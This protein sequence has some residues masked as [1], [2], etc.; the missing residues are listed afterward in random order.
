MT[1]VKALQERFV[2]EGVSGVFVS[3]LL[4]DAPSGTLPT[5]EVEGVY[6]NP[7]IASHLKGFRI[8]TVTS[9]QA[10]TR[11][12][13]RA[14]DSELAPLSAE[15]MEIFQSPD[16]WFWHWPRRTSAGTTTFESIE[17]APGAL[18]AFLAQRLAGLAFTAED[19]MAGFTIVDVLDRIHGNFDSTNVTR[20]FYERFAA[21]HKSLAGEIAGLSEQFASDYSTTLLNRMMFLYFLQKKEFLNGDLWYLEHTLSAV[22][23]LKGRD[24]YYNFYRDALLPLFFERLNDPAGTIED[25]QI[26]DILGKVPYVN[27][28]IFGKTSIEEEFGGRISVPDSAFERILSFFSEYNWHLDTRPAAEDEINP[29]VLGYIFEQFVNSKQM[30]AYYTKDDVTHF[31]TRST[32]LPV[33]LTRLESI[34]VPVWDLAQADPD[35]YIWDSLE[36]GAAIPFP[37]S[38]EAERESHRRPTWLTHAPESIGLPGESWWEVDARRNALE[39]IRAMLAAGEISSVDEA[40]SANLNIEALTVDAIRRISEPATLLAVWQAMT[41]LRIV[42]PTCGSGAFLFAALNLLVPVYTSLLGAMDI[43]K[44]SPDLQAL[45]DEV[46]GHK[47]GRDYFI[48]KHACLSNLYGVDIMPSAVEVARL[49]LF[50]KLASALDS[51]SKIEPLPDLDFNIKTGNI[52]VGARTPEEIDVAGE[53]LLLVDD[54]SSAVMLSARRVEIAYSDFRAA[55]VGGDAEAVKGVRSRLKSLLTEVRDDVNRQYYALE[56]RKGT[57][58]E[59]VLASRPFH[60]FIEFPEVFDKGG[61]DV[62]IGNPPYIA[63]AKVKEY[64]YRGFQTDLLPDIYAPCTERSAQITGPDGRMAIIIP[65]SASFSDGYSELRK[66]LEARFGRLW[67]STFSRRPAALF[68]GNVGVRSTIVI[69]HRGAGENQLLVTK[70]HRWFE[71]FRPALFETLQYFM[72]TPAL[73]RKHG[74]IRLSSSAFGRII[75]AVSARAGSLGALERRNA[76]SHSVGFKTTALYWVSVFLEDPPAYERDGRLTNQTKIGRIKTEDERAA[77]LMLAT[78]ASK[79]ALV[80]WFSTGDDFDVTGGGIKATPVDPSS[81]SERAQLRLECLAGELLASYPNHVMFNL[82]KG[83]YMGNYVLSELR[84]V[85]DEIDEII[86]QELG[87][88]DLLPGLEHAYACLFKPTGEGTGTIRHDPF[89]PSPV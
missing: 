35:R 65:I 72:L 81:F 79:F 88:A 53:G 55:Q 5:I 36:H 44:P 39:S 68:N 66:V 63:K 87:F 2:V 83:K 42:D 69:G 82:Y 21:E 52:L 46:D 10:P 43:A 64:A 62:V 11:A 78:L 12:A 71:A 18:P 58:E 51:P 16:A 47:G 80:W 45:M 48:L 75:E 30:G 37:D 26:N 50:L 34:D 56:K 20:R 57:L 19:H 41:E 9:N 7:A 17:T 25:T 84:N 22:Q 32:L 15:R 23:E 73:K 40:V 85:T 31:M 14:V 8:Y 28:G 33:I 74:W 4:W 6:Y 38:I 86:A 59:W 76:T 54:E 61:F 49:R 27:G 60:W 1:R 24:Y 13:M 3:E 67:V 70:T 77:K 89:E 29:D